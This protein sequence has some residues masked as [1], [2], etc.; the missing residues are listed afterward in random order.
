MSDDTR[1]DRAGILTFLPD[2][3]RSSSAKVWVTL[4]TKGFE[5]L[6]GAP[7]LHEG[8]GFM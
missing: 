7:F 4:D 6:A 5:F 2:F 8:S 3:L 1:E